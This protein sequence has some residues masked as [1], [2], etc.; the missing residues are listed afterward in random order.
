[1]L[2]LSKGTR[3]AERYTLE[4][5]LGRGGEA[6]TWLARDRLTQAGVALKIVPIAG[7]AAR[8]LRD[9]WQTN[10]RLMHAHIVRVF[11]FH[12]SDD[13]TFYS[14]QYIDGPDLAVLSGAPV[15]DI[16]GPV[17]L[18]ADAL[19]YAHAREVVHRDVK[20]ANVLLD[21]NGAPYLIDFGV[22]TEGDDHVGGGSLISASPQ[23][24]DG[25]APSPAGDVFALG[26]LIYELI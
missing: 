17:A 22:A 6:G 2:E 13:A 16:L 1:M 26:G 18:I 3:L 21:A 5:M 4:R 24:L 12:D 23:Q 19:S 25:G 7:N 11:E 14:L 20:V 9:E 15:E 10:L 8:R